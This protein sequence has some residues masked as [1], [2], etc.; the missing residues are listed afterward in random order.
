VVVSA[1]SCSLLN[2]QQDDTQRSTPTIS[3]AFDLLQYAARIR[4]L[5][6]VAPRLP[7]FLPYLSSGD[8]VFLTSAKIDTAGYDLELGFV[9]DC[10]GQHVCFYG[11]SRGSVARFD[12][13][14]E[15]PVRVQLVNGIQ[16]LFS[17]IDRRILQRFVDSVD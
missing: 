16:G 1:L 11:S 17:T 2:G 12:P 14:G 7:T 13:P 4:G 6:H 5:L 8:S 10:Q 15:W 9:P 3:S